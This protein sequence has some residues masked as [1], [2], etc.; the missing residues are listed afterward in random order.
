MNDPT[1]SAYI[2]FEV[3]MV[4]NMK[5]AAFWVVMQCGSYKNRRFGGTQRLTSQILVSLMVEVLRSSET[6]V[7]TRATLCN[8][9]ED[10]IVLFSACISVIV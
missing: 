4:V 6:S 1:L 7:L 5:N 8:I 3:L 2:R 10:G 9:P